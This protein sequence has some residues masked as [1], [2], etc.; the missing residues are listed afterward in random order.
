[1]K[2]DTGKSLLKDDRK[3]DDTKTTPVNAIET[4]IDE[5]RG[6]CF[7][8]ASQIVERAGGLMT[9]TLEIVAVDAEV[10]VVVGEVTERSFGPDPLAQHGWINIRECFVDAPADVGAEIHEEREGL[11]GDAF[12][13]ECRFE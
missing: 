4:E 2:S 3:P 10:A 13:F 12:S 1:C 11:N 7:A 5:R 8:Q 6:G 9:D